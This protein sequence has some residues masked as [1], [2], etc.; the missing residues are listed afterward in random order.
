MPKI[1]DPVKTEDPEGIIPVDVAAPVPENAA[2]KTAVPE[3]EL[4]DW[5]ELEELKIDPAV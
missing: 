5:A 2:P 3:L 1:E 4:P